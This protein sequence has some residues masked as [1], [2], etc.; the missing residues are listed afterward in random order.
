MLD[1]AVVN[2]NYD[3]PVLSNVLKALCEQSRWLKDF[4]R[5]VWVVLPATVSAIIFFVKELHGGEKWDVESS[6]EKNRCFDWYGPQFRV[7]IDEDLVRDET[8]LMK[9]DYIFFYWLLR[10][11]LLKNAN[12]TSERSRKRF[13]PGW[14]SCEVKE[15]DTRPAAEL[16]AVTTAFLDSLRLLWRKLEA[17]YAEVRRSDGSVREGI[18]TLGK[19]LKTSV[20]SDALL[21]A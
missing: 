15:R 20:A 7:R 4:Y 18:P 10:R 14:S 9:I 21:R 3:L 5:A 8:R 11:L 16:V 17:F 19:I 1:R 12:G 13:R 2:I 6:K